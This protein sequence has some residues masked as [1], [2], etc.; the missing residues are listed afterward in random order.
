MEQLVRQLS[1]SENELKK[2]EQIIQR[3]KEEKKVIMPQ[4]GNPNIIKEENERLK[5]THQF[6][7]SYIKDY[8]NQAL[9]LQK[10]LK[11][12]QA[13]WVIGSPTLDL[14]VA[15]YNKINPTNPIIINDVTQSDVL[16]LKLSREM[17]MLNTNNANVGYNP[18]NHGNDYW[19]ASPSTGSYIW[20]LGSSLE[21]AWSNR[22]DNTYAFRPV[23]CLNSDILFKWNNETNKYDIIQN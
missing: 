16:G 8:Q 14:L 19:I 12:N 21:K 2:A 3:L 5:I 15:S 17:S 4:K 6:N 20:Y 1:H 10:Q 22:Y 23:I 18:W 11:N 13:K 7:L 9:D